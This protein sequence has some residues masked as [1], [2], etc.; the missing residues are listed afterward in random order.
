MLT[1]PGTTSVRPIS[2]TALRAAFTYFDK[3]GSG[4][5]TAVQLEAGLQTLGFPGL[6][7]AQIR[8]ALLEADGSGQTASEEFSHARDDVSPVSI[9]CR[10]PS[11][12]CCWS[13][14]SNALFRTCSSWA[15]MV[16][17]W[18]GTGSDSPRV[19]DAS[20][21]MLS[22]NS[23]RISPG[24]SHRH[25]P[26]IVANAHSAAGGMPAT[27]LQQQRDISVR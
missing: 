16:V 18:C 10:W 7:S 21:R 1:R 13:S 5:V 12:P 15:G 14:I 11:W 2:G 26:L 19:C 3:D 27:Q 22:A 17:G 8:Q 24:S 6:S 20:W 4:F 25:W 9:S 23:A